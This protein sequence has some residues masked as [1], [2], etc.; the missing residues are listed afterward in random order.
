MAVAVVEKTG[1]GTGEAGAYERLD[2]PEERQLGRTMCTTAEQS[3][4]VVHAWNPP[5][6]C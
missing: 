2:M 1:A 6:R 3:A 4:G 5:S